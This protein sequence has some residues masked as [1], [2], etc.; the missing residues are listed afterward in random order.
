MIA[1]AQRRRSRE[2]R[3][4]ATATALAFNAPKEIPKAFKDDEKV[5]DRPQ[6]DTPSGSFDSD[7]SWQE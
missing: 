5:Q 6:A 2:L 4:E 7:W 1:A 3:M